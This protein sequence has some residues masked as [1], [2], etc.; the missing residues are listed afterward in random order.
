[1]IHKDGIF[2]KNEHV[3][4]FICSSYWY[5]CQKDH[6]WRGGPIFKPIVQSLGNAVFTS[7]ILE[8][9]TF[10]ISTFAG[11]IHVIYD[12]FVQACMNFL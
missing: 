3:F 8:E 11:T 7:C 5:Q 2:M 9:S 4:L 10:Y 6:K 1:M 12:V